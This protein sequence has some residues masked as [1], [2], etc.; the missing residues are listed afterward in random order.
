MTGD[1]AL[2]AFLQRN[3]L[4][5][6]YL[7]Q[8]RQ[9][10]DPVLEQ[11]LLLNQSIKDEASEAR[12][13]ALIVGINGA[14]G[15]GKSTLADYLCTKI[16]HLHGFSAAIVSLDDFYLRKAERKALSQSVHPL[17]STRG[18]PGTH[19]I[20]L[21]THTLGQLQTQSDGEL[22]LPRFDKSIDD[23]SEPASATL[24]VD[25][26]LFEGWCVGVQPQADEQL[27][28]PVNVLERDK[29]S[30][31]IWRGYVNDALANY[32]PL[33][34]MIDC[35]IM[36]K[37]PAFDNVLRWRI[38]QER[39]LEAALAESDDAHTIQ[40][41]FMSDEAVAA[42]IAYYQRITEHCLETLP[43]QVDHLFT[44]AD[45]RRITDY[46]QQRSKEHRSKEQRLREQR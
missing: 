16:N 28:E 15:S 41:Q 44:L 20:E 1:S 30:D 33:F 39:K 26:V 38:E 25:V 29:D 22:A 7:V 6:S 24:P 3:Q 5:E 13:R 19:D 21:A 10:F 27:I 14:Q 8:A 34:A 36:L 46:T 40:R 9:W 23:R 37:A 18:V 17:L 31:A 12:H 32:Q 43:D 11:L 35:M 42:F 2:M 4:D 45:D